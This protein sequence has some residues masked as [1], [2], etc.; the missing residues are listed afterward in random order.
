MK[1]ASKE[2]TIE[3][4][5]SANSDPVAV[6]HM[7][8]YSICASWTESVASL[9]GELKLQAS[10]NAFTHQDLQVADASAVWSNV[11]A[12]DYPVSGAGSYCWNVSD[13]QYKAFRL[14]WTRTSGEGTLT[15]HI[16]IKGII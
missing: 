14:V 2:I 11:P 12:S 8:G 9:V 4:A 1:A 6:D 16:Q 13:V 10:N 15:G 3:M 5:A 7:N